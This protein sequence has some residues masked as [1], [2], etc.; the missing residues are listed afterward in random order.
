MTPSDE[1]SITRYLLG[2]LAERD[3]IALEDR[4]FADPEYLQQVRAIEKDLIDEYARDELSAADRVKFEQYFL[5][6]DERRKQL[7]FARALVRVTSDYPGRLSSVTPQ[8][9]MWNA[10]LS[11]LR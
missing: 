9:G 5:A 8:R 6:S 4:A 1:Q 2:G 3:Q 11:S 10:L 7:G